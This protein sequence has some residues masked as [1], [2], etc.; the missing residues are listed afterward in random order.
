M[1]TNECDDYE[2]V[3]DYS[4]GVPTTDNFFEL[5]SELRN[6]FSFLFLGRAEILSSTILSRFGSRWIL[7]YPLF[8]VNFARWSTRLGL[9]LSEVGIS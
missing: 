1:Q 4:V 5:L 8:G 7:F 3:C 9:D 2:G 6:S